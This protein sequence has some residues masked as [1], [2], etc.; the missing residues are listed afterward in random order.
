[1]GIIR[2]INDQDRKRVN[3]LVLSVGSVETKKKLT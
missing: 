2:K 1:M 3:E